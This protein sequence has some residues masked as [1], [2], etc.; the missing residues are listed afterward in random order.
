MNEGRRL[1]RALARCFGTAL[2][3]AWLAGAAGVSE[4]MAREQPPSFSM[5]NSAVK[6]RRLDSGLTVVQQYIPGCSGFAVA[7]LVPAG[8]GH[9]PERRSGMAHLTEHLL[10]RA[11]PDYSAGRLAVE[12]EKL[13]ARRG[14]LTTADYVLFWEMV[15]AAAGMQTLEIVSGRFKGL[16]VDAE[17]LKQE[18]RLLAGELRDLQRNSWRS[19]KAQARTAL[20]AETDAAVLPQGREE[21][22][23]QITEAELGEFYRRYYRL[24]RAVLAV[25]GGYDEEVLES[26]LRQLF[27]ASGTETPSQLADVSP[28]PVFGSE[29]KP[30]D[31]EAAPVGEPDKQVGQGTEISGAVLWTA[32][33][34]KR[35]VP[36]YAVVEALNWRGPTSR[37][38]K[39]I[40]EYGWQGQVGLLE[41]E[42]TDAYASWALNV[43]EELDPREVRKALQHDW[44]TSAA[45]VPSYPELE[46]ARK[47]ALVK[48]YRQWQEPA[49][50]VQLLAKAQYSGNLQ[51]LLDFPRLV[52]SYSPQ[53]VGEYNRRLALQSPKA[54]Y[55]SLQGGAQ[56]RAYGP[57]PDEAWA[58]ETP[59][60]FLSDNGMRLTVSADVHQPMVYLRGYI[61]GGSLCDP[62]D[63]PGLTCFAAGLLGKGTDPRT[64]RSFADE[65]GERGMALSFKGD[66]QVIF[67]SGSCLRE[68]IHRFLDILCNA[69][70]CSDPDDEI[71]DRWRSQ[72]TAELRQREESA[73]S[74][75]TAL[76]MEKLYPSGHPFGR[77]YGGS[78]S[79]AASYSRET[80]VRHLR[81]CVQPARVGLCFSGGVN[82]EIVH[83]KLQARLGDWQ[84]DDTI[85]PLEVP[86]AEKAR[87][88]Q[89]WVM[90][91]SGGEFMLVGQLGPG[92]QDPDY[93]AFNLL[94]QILA[95]SAHLSRLP[96]RIIH[97]EHLGT[98]VS[99]RLLPSQ[100]AAPWAA[101]MRLHP[102]KSERALAI[103][104]QEMA[105]LAEP[106]PSEE[107]IQRAKTAL[108]NQALLQAAGPSSRTGLLCTVDYYRLDDN[109]LND[110][111]SIYRDITPLQLHVAA[112][113]WFDP[114]RLT[115]VISKD[116][117]KEER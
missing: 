114:T 73:E 96:L 89:R 87:K 65:L 11:V 9:D 38:A 26:R 113:K 17:S 74:R 99:S 79:A 92:R 45:D 51:Q 59:E 8:A 70:R 93:N 15:P 106:G 36:I 1:R 2:C 24:D 91:Q 23:A 54:V 71:V 115:V 61:D 37:W 53:Q 105:R 78:S 31:A 109:Y 48:H 62:E 4:V 40:K 107:E 12:W 16:A 21:D 117:L 111:Q 43:G 82:A 68:D 18:Q 69:L 103:V 94:N 67:I 6:C 108:E 88:G 55:V 44:Q 7:L 50:R 97:I 98:K 58:G 85:V 112:K 10:Y 35:E 42:H 102:G 28:Q 5:E 22:I 84:N 14:A 56:P 104:K 63:S 46:A 83:R 25:A 29:D 3:A 49:Q 80:A 13:G 90:R 41:P 81:R 100:S 77:F 30:A 57:G 95:S 66:R 76:L 27:A 110:V 64:G 19:V 116:P 75:A 72:L 52:R 32:P 33:L 39:K 47:R 101:V 20:A 86:A 34:D 60:R